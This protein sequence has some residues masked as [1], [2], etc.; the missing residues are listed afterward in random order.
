MSAVDVHPEDLLDALRERALRPEEQERLRIHC[1][2]CSACAFEVEHR[3]LMQQAPVESVAVSSIE[4]AME[5][6][7]Q[8]TPMRLPWRRMVLVA[9]ISVACA[10]SVA[11]MVAVQRWAKQRQE[12]EPALRDHFSRRRPEPPVP[13]TVEPEP[14]SAQDHEIDPE[15]E[16]LDKAAARFPARRVQASLRRR[17]VSGGKLRRGGREERDAPIDSIVH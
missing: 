7:P 15:V 16:S 11:A 6:A 12:T 13:K 1:E 17:P 8:R 10:S 9:S 4:R 5:Q 3:S 14:Q 2:S